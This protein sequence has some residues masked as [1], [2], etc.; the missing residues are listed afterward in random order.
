VIRFRVLGPVE[1]AELPG[2]KPRALLAR[3]VLE[4][5]R[6]V[7][8]ETLVDA[9]WREPPASAH[10]VVQVYVSQLRKALGADAI[11]TRAPG[12]L[13]RVEPGETDIGRFEQLAEAAREAR[14]PA[15]RA[16]LLREALELWRGPALAEFDDEPFAEA[17]ARR[18]AELRLHALEERV[19]ARLELG[20]HAQLVPELEALVAQEPL[21]ERPRAQL[22]LALYRSGRQAEA[23]ERYRSGRQLLVEELGI[24]PG[25][26]LQELERAILRQDA[27]LAEPGG[28]P[29]GRGSIVCA[30]PVLATLVAPLGRDVVLV[31]LV[32]EAAGLRA[33]TARLKA[34]RGEGI[35]TASFVSSS[36][37]AD[38][39][40]LAAEQDAELLLCG[41]LDPNDLE[42]LFTAAPCDVAVAPRLE[43]A[44]EPT[45]PVLVPFG[46]AREEWAALELSAWIARAHA[47]PLRLLGTEAASGR[48]DASRLL[49]SASL[50]LQRF[51]G[52]AAE[53]ALV[54]PGADGILRERGSLLV[55]SLPAAQLDPT[56]MELAERTTAP[57]LLVHGGLRPSGLAPEH[58]L[59]RFSWSLQEG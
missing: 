15:R 56:R 19:D 53:P 10:K 3:L 4:P 26:A 31:G 23:L 27:A 49:A 24:E 57:L 40:R 28:Q 29:R 43:L 1:P 52:A 30:V 37:G 22:M 36:P 54:E 6:V 11:E 7:P 16:E 17:A 45:A 13:L 59:T 58:T 44:F 34:L 46:G 12:Y 14:E 18:L 55:A 39:A 50:A 38:L 47:L 5:G 20:E 9:L 48:R 51:A 32:P 35:R 33:E 41:P 8:A 2:G 21:R 25:P 42:S